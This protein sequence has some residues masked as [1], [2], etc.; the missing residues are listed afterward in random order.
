VRPHGKVKVPVEVGKLQRRI[1]RRA[2]FERVPHEDARLRLVQTHHRRKRPIPET[3]RFDLPEQGRG[4]VQVF[5]RAESIY[6]GAQ[7]KLRGLD[8]KARF[9]VKELDDRENGEMSG[10]ELLEQGL[11]VAIEDRPGVAVI[12]YERA[13]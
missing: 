10:Q 11:P 8:P 9:V 1:A 5:R 6:T 7:L 13:Q 12:A 2:H 4:V 3:G